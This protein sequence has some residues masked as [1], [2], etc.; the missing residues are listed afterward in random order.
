MQQIELLDRRPCLSVLRLAI[1]LSPFAEVGDP[2]GASAKGSDWMAAA[3]TIY[4][5]FCRALSALQQSLRLVLLGYLFS[6]DGQQIC[7]R[8]FETGPPY[9]GPCRC[10]EL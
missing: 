7:S 8:R 5:F 10:A 9:L 1:F 6:I 3:G 2:V 4:L